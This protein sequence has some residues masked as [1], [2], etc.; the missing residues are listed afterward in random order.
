MK[1]PGAEQAVVDVRE[2]RNYCLDPEHHRGCHKAR[3]FASALG[4][5]KAD[6]EFL[7]AALLRAAR[8]AEAVAGESDEYGDRFTVDFELRRMGRRAIVRGAWIVARGET[9]PRLTSCFIP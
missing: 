8:E 9:F 5:T 2:L 4:L 6:A 7:R 1:L 3:V